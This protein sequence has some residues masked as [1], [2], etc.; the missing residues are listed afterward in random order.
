MGWSL[1]GDVLRSKHVDGVRVRNLS[2]ES[3]ETVILE[4]MDIMGWIVR[5]IKMKDATLDAVLVQ[6][7]DVYATHG[8]GMK[9][10][11]HLLHR[12]HGAF[13][14]H[15]REH[16]T[17]A[18]R[19]AVDEVFVFS[20]QKMTGNDLKVCNATTDGDGESALSALLSQR[21]FQDVVQCMASEEGREYLYR[22][23]HQVHCTD[24]V[25][26]LQL[27]HCYKGTEQETPRRRVVARD[28][29]AICLQRDSPF[30]VDFAVSC[31]HKVW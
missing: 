7:G 20:V 9:E 3:V 15:F 18:I 19:F 1:V 24:I 17:A 26:F 4:M 14:I 12:M 5:K 21:T 27:M 31:N 6:M 13:T 16:Y 11:G 22:Y 30:A 28:I 2:L 10:Y 23:L 8:I 29:E 25:L